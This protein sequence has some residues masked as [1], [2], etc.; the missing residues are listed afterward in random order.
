MAAATADGR[1]RRS[2]RSARPPGRKT[3]AEKQRLVQA[4]TKGGIDFA[5]IQHQRADIISTNATEPD[6]ESLT[7]TKQE[8]DYLI[9]DEKRELLTAAVEEIR[10][11]TGYML[12]TYRFPRSN[13]DPTARIQL[14]EKSYQRYKL[15]TIGNKKKTGKTRKAS[16]NKM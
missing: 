6:W 3:A 9:F 14:Q 16:K 7:I 10:L 5:E 8:L 15:Q 11:F 13:G 4:I 12:I 1:L 2:P